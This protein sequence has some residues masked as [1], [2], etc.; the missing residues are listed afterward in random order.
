MF[1]RIEEAVLNEAANYPLAGELIRYEKGVV[2]RRETSQSP[3]GHKMSVINKH[4]TLPA[5]PLAT[6]PTGHES[7]RDTYNDD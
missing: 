3:M 5:S 2:G 1:L 7:S 6:E 4:R